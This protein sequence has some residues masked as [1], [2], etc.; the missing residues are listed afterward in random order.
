MLLLL[1]LLLLFLLHLPLLMLLLLLAKRRLGQ[2]RRECAACRRRALTTAVTLQPAQPDAAPT[3][4][5]LLLQTPPCIRH[6]S[7]AFRCTF[8]AAAWPGRSAAAFC[9]DSFTANCQPASAGASLALPLLLLISSCITLAPLG[10]FAP[11]AIYW[12]AHQVLDD[13]RFQP[14]VPL[15][16]AG[17]GRCNLAAQQH[18][19]DRWQPAVC[20]KG[21]GG[22]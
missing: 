12:Q 21:R 7:S 3:G 1:L 6:S 17:L 10:C 4:P 14:I 5:Q 11:W 22:L 16:H 18:M 8:L 15:V 13:F 19:I 2:K 9:P 20:R